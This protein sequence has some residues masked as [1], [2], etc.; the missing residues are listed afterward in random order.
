MTLIDYIIF[1]A[2]A[3][4][5]L[6][7][8]KKGFSNEALSLATWI[9]AYVIAKLFSLPFATLLIEF[10]NPPSARQPAAFAAL[11][12]LTLILG[13]LI[14]VL[15]KELVSATGLSTTDRL[16]GMV[17]GAARG[18]VLVVFCISMLSRLTDVPED[19]WWNESMAIPH[20]L[21]VEDWT[22][23]MGQAAWKKVTALS[24]S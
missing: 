20:L 4:S 22:N 7:S 5:A 13:A 17:F 8:L 21:L 11:F 2:V 16:L 1:G 10:I 3:L 9:S 19:P 14:K 23:D 18:L 24:G 12:V 15:F 6:L